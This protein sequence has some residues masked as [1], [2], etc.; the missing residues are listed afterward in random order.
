MPVDAW[1]CDVFEQEIESWSRPGDRLS[2]VLHHRLR[3]AKEVQL[4][5]WTSVLERTTRFAGGR[6]AAGVDIKTLVVAYRGAG[7]TARA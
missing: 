5:M 1:Q 4:H 3:A 6:M 7:C 2:N